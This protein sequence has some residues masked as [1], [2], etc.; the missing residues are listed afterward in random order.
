MRVADIVRT[1]ARQRPDHPALRW[2]DGSRTWAE[3]DSRSNRVAQALRASGV[4]PGDRVALL[5]R[6]GPEH[7]ELTYAAAKLGAALTPVNFRLAAA[8]VRQVIA[9][10]RPRVWVVGAEFSELA[11]RVAAE[12]DDPPEVVVVGPGYAQWVDPRP[13]DDPD[14]PPPADD[15]VLQM[16]TSGTTGVAKGVELTNANLEAC[17]SLWDELLGLGD[18]DAI[19]LAPLP[20]FHIGG[21]TWALAAHRFGSTA[22]VVRDPVP[23]DLVEL[24]ATEGITHA[25][26]VPA[27][28][29]F[30]LAVPGVRERDWSA[31]RAI[32]YG[33]SP[34][35]E[36]VL[37]DAV[38]TFGCRFRQAYGLTETTATVVS[39]PPS[40]H[41][42]DGANAHRLRA[43]GLPV[44][45]VTVRV[46]D[47][48]TCEDVPDG[49]VGEFWIAGPN[50][51]R[52]YFGRPEL[53]AEVVVEGGWFRSGDVGFRDADGY[54]F[55][56][57]RTKDVIIS[58]AENVYPTEVENVLAGHPGVA[59]CAVIGVPSE[60]WGETPKAIVV[61]AP[62]APD[63]T[64]DE[65]IE[66][67]RSELA[68]FKCPTSVE[69]VDE[70]PR[71]PAGKILK[72]ELRGP[73]W[74][75]RERQVG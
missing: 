40:D 23:A 61:R 21:H 57:D 33:A 18:E 51:M 73:Y 13:D 38:K 55:L 30:M 63:V 64:P 20:L 22:V 72:K 43:C 3:L 67:C 35:T 7:F 58:G 66:H 62:D 24:M 11:E 1:Y 25:G 59:E 46:V 56:R 75:G 50:V 45:G 37:S 65:L 42:P 5:D 54:L 69:F 14:E 6:N 19:C 2:P 12:S 68:R 70:L 26:L 44:S 36:S 41:D 48:V 28:L 9:D 53:T 29:Q 16:Y 49:E 60:R 47:P 8:E 34:I 10:A 32:L 52:G 39:L 15:V 27:L 31:L 4:G 71:N 74:E 17:L